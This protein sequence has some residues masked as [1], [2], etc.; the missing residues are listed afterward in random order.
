[1]KVYSVTV[2]IPDSGDGL[3]E[4]RE[5]DRI[6]IRVAISNPIAK[7][8]VQGLIASVKAK[9]QGAWFKPA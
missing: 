8:M 7:A 1:M 4:L 2:T 6:D 5:D 9:L 3:V